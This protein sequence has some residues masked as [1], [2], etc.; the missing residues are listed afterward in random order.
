MLVDLNL[1]IIVC[2]NIILITYPNVIIGLAS[3]PYHNVNLIWALPLRFS[4]HLHDVI[5][6]FL[7]ICFTQTILYTFYTNTNHLSVSP[8]YKHILSHKKTPEQTV[9]FISSQVSL[10]LHYLEFFFYNFHKGKLYFSYVSCFSQPLLYIML[11]SFVFNINTCINISYP[12]R[13]LAKCLVI[14]LLL[15]IFAGINI[16]LWY[17][18]FTKYFYYQWTLYF[19]GNCYTLYYYKPH[20]EYSGSSKSYFQHSEMTVTSDY[21]IA[22]FYTISKLKPL[23]IFF[24]LGLNIVTMS[25]T[26]LLIFYKN[27]NFTYIPLSVHKLICMYCVHMYVLVSLN[28]SMKYILTILCYTGLLV[29]IVNILHESSTELLEIIV[30]VMSTGLFVIMYKRGTGSLTTFNGVLYSQFLTCRR[31][32]SKHFVVT[33]YG[34]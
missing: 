34:S 19:N 27:F 29:N 17:T 5:T 10:I 3:F 31:P 4:C 23:M 13:L 2:L 7:T 32:L 16:C 28:N 1:I 26:P 18:S 12:L 14:L 9:L 21:L 33:R 24:S 20:L 8:V 6:S 30:F 22:T 15:I 11:M 25:C